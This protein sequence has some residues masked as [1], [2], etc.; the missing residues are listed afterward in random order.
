[1]IQA[2]WNELQRALLAP[3]DQIEMSV[4]EP[5]LRRMLVVFGD[6]KAGSA[7]RAVACRDAFGCAQANGWKDP[8]LQLPAGSIERHHLARVGLTQDP[9]TDRIRLEV[10]L[11]E[12]ELAVYRRQRRRFLHQPL[13]DV[14]LSSALGRAGFKTTTASVSKRQS[15]HC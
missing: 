2:Q 13:I 1:M 9:L 5:Y 11:E 12:A 14:A 15:G 7:D 8:L 3:D 4:V 6:A 10:A